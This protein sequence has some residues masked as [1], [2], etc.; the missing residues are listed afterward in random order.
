[1]ADLG[2]IANIY[3]PPTSSPRP[4]IPITDYDIQRGKALG[5]VLVHDAREFE[6]VKRGPLTGYIVR[7][8]GIRYKQLWPSHGQR[9]PQ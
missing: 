3:T 6:P 5:T 1:M 8:I 7:Q 4:V 2:T 9:F